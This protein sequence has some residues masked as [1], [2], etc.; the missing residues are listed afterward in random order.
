MSTDAGQAPANVPTAGEQFREAV[1]L[2]L[3][4]AQQRRLRYHLER[5]TT[6]GITPE[7]LTD[8]E[9][10]GSSALQGFVGDVGPQASKIMQRPDASRLAV[11]IAQIVEQSVERS[12]PGPGPVMLG[13]L[14]GAYL[15]HGEPGTGAERAEQA[16]TGAIAGAIATA[17]AATVSANI[18]GLGTIEYVRADG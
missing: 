3:E 10:L 17:A 2:A 14:L 9:A 16:V 4:D 15:S 8:L 5:L 12:V 18:A 1:A 11:T 13:A 6:V 7:E